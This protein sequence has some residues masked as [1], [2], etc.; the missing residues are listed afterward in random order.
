MIKRI[1]VYLRERIRRINIKRKLPQIGKGFWIGPLY[2]I[3]GGEHIYIGRHFKSNICFRIEA[4][5]SFNGEAFKPRI[6]IGDNASFGQSCHIG[7]IN[8]IVIGDNFLAGSN[9]LI[10]DHQHGDVR[11][12]SQLPPSGRKL[13]S[14]GG[15]RIGNNVWIAD[16]ATIMPG[17]TIGDG[18]IV[19]AHSVVTHD[20]PPSC[21]AVGIP[22]KV[23]RRLE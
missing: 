9:V 6:T 13:C 14:Q 2:Q 21:V 7:C 4:I 3:R 1:W 18:A 19:G 12:K 23:L 17:V 8:E 22:A 20:I 15:I 5:D 10:I 11:Q 16:S